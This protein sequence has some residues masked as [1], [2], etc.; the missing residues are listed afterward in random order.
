VTISVDSFASPASGTG[1]ITYAHVPGARVDGFV[2][3]ITQQTGSTDEVTSVTYGGVNVPRVTALFKSSGET[4]AVYLYFLGLG[5]PSGTQTVNVNV[6]GTASTK[7]ITTWGLIS[8]IPKSLKVQTF[9]NSINS[10]SVADPSVV[11]PLSGLSCWC[12]LVG[13]SGQDL[14]ANVTQLTNWT[15]TLEQQWTAQVG[16]HYRYNIIG[17]ADVTAGWTQTAEDA[18]IIAAAITEYDPPVATVIPR[19]RGMRRSIPAA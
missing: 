6:N 3:G 19:T 18:T 16:C 15:A 14:A 13:L 17:T 4:G 5:I 8:S 2:C 12:G 9:D 7:R 11:L 1:L 10:D